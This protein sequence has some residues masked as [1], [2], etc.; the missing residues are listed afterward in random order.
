MGMSH[1]RRRR[2]LRGGTTPASLASP[3][4]ELFPPG[5]PSRLPGISTHAK[6]TPGGKNTPWTTG[7]W[8]RDM[9][10][11]ALPALPRVLGAL[12][13]TRLLKHQNR[14]R[15]GTWTSPRMGTSLWI[16]RCHKGLARKMWVLTES[17]PGGKWRWLL[18]RMETSR[19][20]FSR[21]KREDLPCPF[22]SVPPRG[23][24]ACLEVGLGAPFPPLEAPV[25]VPWR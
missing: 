6:L 18:R 17:F 14:P 13:T 24:C 15:R 16:S 1:A 23:L 25:K 11:E 12:G 20:L 9:M 19:N 3:G 21:R 7:C 2:L 4:E 10:L 22:P 8:D 5:T